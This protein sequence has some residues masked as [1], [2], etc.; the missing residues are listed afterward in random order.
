MTSE[1]KEQNQSELSH[2]VW[3]THRFSSELKIDETLSK[4]L[5]EELGQEADEFFPIGTSI[6]QILRKYGQLEGENTT[7]I[8]V[9][10]DK[11]YSKN[12]IPEPW[13]SRWIAAPIGYLCSKEQREEWLGDLQEIIHEMQA[14][15]YP[16]WI[17]N[18]ICVG[19]TSILIFS[20]FEI[21]ISDFFTLLK[22]S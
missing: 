14:K 22:R 8:S 3:C 20:V 10:Q 2:E 5:R 19:K 18:L 9:R 15:K 12:N 7:I 17:I 6:S 21:K 16:R 1:N 11:T 13:A 4:L